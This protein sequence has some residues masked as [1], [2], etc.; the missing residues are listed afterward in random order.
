MNTELFEVEATHDAGG[1]KLPL[2]RGVWASA[3][4]GGAL[5][6]YR[7][8]LEWTWRDMR[9]MEYPTLLACMMNPSTATEFNGDRTLNWVYRWASSRGFGRLIVVNADAYRCTDQARLSEVADPCGP[10]NLPHI[11][12][13]AREADLIVLG[14]GMP[15]VKAV[16]GHG[17][18]MAHALLEAGHKLHAWQTCKDG[19][20]KHPLYVAGDTEAKEW[21]P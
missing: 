5:D 21:R 19:T 4:Y 12:E 11:L 13:A 8:R 20:P 16:R 3:I 7:Y 9:T 18:R 2:P 10:D 17:L 6:C 1:S 15:K 14:Y